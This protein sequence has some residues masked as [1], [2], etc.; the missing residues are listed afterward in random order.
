M[1]DIDKAMETMKANLAAS[2]GKSLAQWVLAARGF[3]LARHGE[4]VQ[5]LKTE[6]GLGHGYAN[7]IAHTMNQ[8]AA[9]TS[10]D[11]AALVD[12]QYA[13]PK[14]P[15]RPI[16][17]RLAAV[18]QGFG[19]DVELAPKK[20]YVSVRRARQFAILQPSTATRFDVGLVLKAVAPAGRLEASGSFSAMVTHRVRLA[21]AKEVDAELVGWMKQAHDAAG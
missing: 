1:A 16:Y 10:G 12:A 15:L 11:S 7:L 6:H 17:D 9:A 13:G 5:R 8:S 2:T 21:S 18:L 20:A 19:T 4:I 3:G 14:A